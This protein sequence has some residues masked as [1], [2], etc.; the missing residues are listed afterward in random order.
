MQSITQR[1]AEELNARQPQVDAAVALLDD[2]ATV[3]F[4]ARYRKEVTGALDDTQLRRLEERLRYLR[5]LEE[6]RE[7][8]LRS[9]DE[10]GKLSETLKNDILTADSKNRLEDLYLPYKPKRRTKGQIAIEAGLEPL[11]DALFA[12]PTLDPEATA[13]T[14]ID[15]DR[16]V[17]DS[18]AA[19]DGAKYI[20]MERFAEDADLIGGLRDFLAGEGLLTAAV[21]DGKENDGAKFRDYFEHA[22]PL[23]KVPGL[24]TET[25]IVEIGEIV[26]AALTRDFGIAGPRLAVAGLNPHAGEDGEIGREDIEII[27]PAVEALR[28]TGATVLGPLS[29][30]TLFHAEARKRY[31]AALCM[32][33]D[34]ALIPIKTLAFW[35]GVN[36]TL[37]LP[38]VRTSPDHGT[39]LDIAG[40]G[41]ADLRSMLAAIRMAA[42]MANARTR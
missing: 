34:Q 30:D 9:I 27:A 10:Q 7:A 25:R 29:A 18:K 38:I 36:V 40:T 31:D 16:G 17:A 6:R 12:D 33:H 32:Y 24:V 15:A 42:E 28:G 21:I 23:A 14:Y 2:G 41:K 20:L 39:A 3:P 35:D 26:L 13:T 19:L 11:A 1:I 37:G 5:E 4:I 22:E 8:I